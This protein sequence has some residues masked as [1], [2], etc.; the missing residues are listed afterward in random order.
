VELSETNEA[1]INDAAALASNENED[2][3]L[4]QMEEYRQEV[5][6]LKGRIAVLE[7]ELEAEK[8]RYCD[9]SIYLFLFFI[10]FI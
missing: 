5:Y 4:L 8:S 3:K 1:E 10:S 9:A 2:E 6:N 7:E